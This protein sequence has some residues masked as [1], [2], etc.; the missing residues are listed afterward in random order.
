MSNFRLLIPQ[1]KSLL[2]L[3][4]HV[5]ELLASPFV[6]SKFHKLIKKI[7]SKITSDFH[8]TSQA[9]DTCQ[10]P[11]DVHLPTSSFL[12][13]DHLR[14]LM[15]QFRKHTHTHDKA[16]IGHALSLYT[17]T[18]LTLLL[19]KLTDEWKFGNKIE[20]T[21][22]QK[23]IV[24]LCQTFSMEF[25]FIAILMLEAKTHPLVYTFGIKST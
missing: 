21:V 3:S 22:T 1:K 9:L 8:F 10:K 6:H 17:V 13:G 15:P 2:T 19:I 23:F 12:Q 14:F 11:E 20:V 16:K 4:V 5:S 24:V 25:K 18:H 7:P